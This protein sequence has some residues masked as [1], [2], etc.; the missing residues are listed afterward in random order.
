MRQEVDSIDEL[1]HSKM[2]IFRED[3]DSR[4]RVSTD[5]ERVPQGV[6]Q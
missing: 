2:V 5:V 1:M 6:E 4:E 3:V